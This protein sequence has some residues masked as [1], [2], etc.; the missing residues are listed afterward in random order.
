[1]IFV[2]GGR[3]EPGG[4]CKK[5]GGKRRV[6]NYSSAFG[7]GGRGVCSGIR[8]G[9]GLLLPSGGGGVMDH[10]RMLSDRGDGKG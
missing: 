6:I 9:R 8:R 4:S 7:A 5:G 10:G 3:K 1:M 2:G